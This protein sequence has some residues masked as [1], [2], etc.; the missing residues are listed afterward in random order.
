M[1]LHYQRQSLVGQVFYLPWTHQSRGRRFNGEQQL[2]GATQSNEFFVRNPDG[3]FIPGWRGHVVVLS[4]NPT[5][6]NIMQSAPVTRALLF[7][8]HDS[9]SLAEQAIV[10]AS[11]ASRALPFLDGVDVLLS[12]GRTYEGKEMPHWDALRERMRKGA[13]DL[14]FQLD[15][16]IDTSG[17]LEAA[18]VSRQRPLVIGVQKEQPDAPE[19]AD[20]YVPASGQASVDLAT[21]G[22]LHLTTS[23]TMPVVVAFSSELAQLPLSS[24][25]SVIS[26]NNAWQNRPPLHLD[27]STISEYVVGQR[28]IPEPESDRHT[29][30]ELASLGRPIEIRVRYRVSPHDA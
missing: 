21:A 12:H 5:Q 4:Q 29:M 11:P 14:A 17:T 10:Y 18:L 6:P 19:K 22:Y 8:L 7:G 20:L 23:S 1:A 3:E 26:A 15:D 9:T 30:V 13:G 16:G 28:R 25:L 27:P 24:F 2:Y